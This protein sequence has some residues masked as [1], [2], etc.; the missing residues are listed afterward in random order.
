MHAG[1]KLLEVRRG[2]GEYNARWSITVLARFVEHESMNYASD[3][4]CVYS[5]GRVKRFTVVST[6]FYDKKLCLWETEIDNEG[7]D[8]G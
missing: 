5:G 8:S 1:V 2:I 3:G 7:N 6:S 4:H